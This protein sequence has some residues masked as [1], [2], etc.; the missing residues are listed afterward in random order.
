[1]AVRQNGDIEVPALHRLET[2]QLQ[3]IPI[4]FEMK[5]VEMDFAQKYQDNNRQGKPELV[6]SWVISKSLIPVSYTHLTLPTKA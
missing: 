2:G 1:M 5:M 6:F 3:D 4:N